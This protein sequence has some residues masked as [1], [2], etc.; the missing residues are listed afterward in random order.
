MLPKI[1]LDQVE[2]HCKLLVNMVSCLYSTEQL[3]TTQYQHVTSFEN[4]KAPPVEL[5]TEPKT[6]EMH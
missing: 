6:P 4:L 1:V 5:P 3:I 2:Q